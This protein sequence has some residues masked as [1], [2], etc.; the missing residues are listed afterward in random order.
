MGCGGRRLTTLKRSHGSHY[1]ELAARVLREVIHVIGFDAIDQLLTNR[2][3]GAPVVDV[4]GNYLGIFSEK[5]A[6]RVLIGAIYDQL[7]GTAVRAYMDLDRNRIIERR[8]TLLD[9]A[10]RFQQTP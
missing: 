10:K 5:T 3:S 2:I 6:M 1:V 9:V 8:E 4:E 7:P